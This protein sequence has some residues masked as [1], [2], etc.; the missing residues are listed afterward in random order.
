MGIVLGPI[1]AALG[2]KTLKQINKTEQKKGAGMAM[3]AIV[4]GVCAAAA[5]VVF[6]LMRGDAKYLLSLFI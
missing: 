2:A 3:L 6:T 4:L 1:G 5:Y